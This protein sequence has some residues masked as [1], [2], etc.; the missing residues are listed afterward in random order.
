MKFSI[1]SKLIASVKFV[2][3]IFSKKVQRIRNLTA[4]PKLILEMLNKRELL[5]PGAFIIN[6]MKRTILNFYY[7]MKL[8]LTSLFTIG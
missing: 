7:N 4:I 5:L 3:E 6:L 1:K 2:T 8:I